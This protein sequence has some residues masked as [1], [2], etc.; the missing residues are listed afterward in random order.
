MHRILFETGYL[1]SVYGV[2]HIFLCL[3]IFLFL[4]FR[5][6]KIAKTDE[7]EEVR[8]IAGAMSKVIIVSMVAYMIFLI[9]SYI[10][11]VIPY[12]TGNYIQI[13]GAV[14]R[15]STKKGGTEYFSVN[16]VDFECSSGMLWGYFK[17]GGTNFL[18]GDGQYL[19]IRYIP[20]K[21]GNTIVYI[22]QLLPEGRDIR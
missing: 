22:E 16:G 6:K 21:H 8:V 12:K 2:F 19:R 18:S 14:R 15:Y 13:E 5:M 20:G 1:G 3:G 11:V 17:Y 9:K 4:Y 10:D 7:R